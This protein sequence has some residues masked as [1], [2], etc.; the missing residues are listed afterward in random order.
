ME[1]SCCA[2]RSQPPSQML[3]GHLEV[4]GN[5]EVVSCELEVTQLNPKPHVTRSHKAWIGG[6]MHEIPSQPVALEF[7]VK[8]MSKGPILGECCCSH[9]I[10]QKLHTRSCTQSSCNKHSTGRCRGEVCIPTGCGADSFMLDKR[11]KEQ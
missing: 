7:T 4:I 1:A 8:F 11:S 10:E 5:R 9:M 2:L 3:N 6:Y